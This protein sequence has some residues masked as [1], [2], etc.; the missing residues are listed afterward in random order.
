MLSPIHSERLKNFSFSLDTMLQLS[1][2]DELQAAF[3]KLESDFKNQIMPLGDKNL[4]SVAHSQWAAYLTEMH[5][6]MRLLPTELMF[7]RSARQPEKVEE[8]LSQVRQCLGKLR[9]YC[10][11]LLEKS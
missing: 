5:K 6:Q 7:L 2:R 3:V 1:D 9:S 4:D 11:T 10:Q 8:R